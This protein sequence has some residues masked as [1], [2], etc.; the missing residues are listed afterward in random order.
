MGRFYN[1]DISGKFWVGIQPSDDISNLVNYMP[2]DSYN[3]KS[4]GCS[5]ELDE[6]ENYCVDCFSSLEEH[7]Q[8][9]KDED[10]YDDNVLW[11]EEQQFIYC[12]N[13]YEHCQELLDSMQRLRTD[14]HPEI[15][16]ELK[17]IER[18]D[19][20][21]DAHTGV[22]NNVIDVLNKVTT[23]MNETECKAV[24]V[25]VARYIIGFQLEYCFEQNEICYIYCE[26]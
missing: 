13:K 16:A 6:E 7:I 15:I 21:L 23:N 3:W 17:K 14:I 24:S 18:D 10:N 11:C 25:Y 8:A 5:L 2:K 12:L 1:G 26:Y 20:I 4:C 9:A 19:D 22:F